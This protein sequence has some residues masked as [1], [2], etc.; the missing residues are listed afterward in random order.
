MKGVVTEGETNREM[1]TRPLYCFNWNHKIYIF[2][3]KRQ[4]ERFADWIS[5]GLSPRVFEGRGETTWKIP[6]VELAPGWVPVPVI[7]CGQ[8]EYGAS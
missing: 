6:T 8:I 3:N 5:D 4:L 7:D 2:T 1:N